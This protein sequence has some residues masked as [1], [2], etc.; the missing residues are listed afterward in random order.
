MEVAFV[1][2][3]SFLMVA[4]PDAQRFRSILRHD[5]VHFLDCQSIYKI[6]SF[7]PISQ[8]YP[9]SKQGTVSK[10]KCCGD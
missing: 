9:G 5:N 6:D 3:L 2:L 8:H 10:R 1:P 4:I 7:S